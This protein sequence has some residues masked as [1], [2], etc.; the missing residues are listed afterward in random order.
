MKK[1]LNILLFLA[2][3]IPCNET[4]AQITFEKTFGS[5][6]FDQANSVRQTPDGGY[7]IGG[8][9]LLKIDEW[10]ALEWTKPYPSQFAN[11]TFDGGYILITSSSPDI[12][13]TKVD[14]DGDTVWQTKN[15]DGIWANEGF[16]ITQT[17][18][19]GYIV[20]GRYQSVTGSGMLLMKL[21]KT[22]NKLWRTTFTEATSA[23]FNTGH[24]VQQTADNGYIIT[25]TSQINY[26]DSTRNKDVFIVK[27]DS[28]G[29]EK[30]RRFFGG[31]KDDAG[32]F[33]QQDLDKNYLISGRTDSYVSGFGTDMYLIKLDTN[34]DSLWTKT[35]G[36]NFM[37]TSSG[38]WTTTDGGYILTGSSNTFSNGDFD[39]YVV[40]TNNNGDTLWTKHYGGTGVDY[41]SSVQQTSDNGY[42]FAGLTSILGSG[43]NNM[44]ILKTDSLGEVL[45]P[46][47]VTKKSS[48]SLNI[49]VY[50]NPS[51]GIF[52]IKSPTDK[53]TV[54]IINLLGQTI[55]SESFNS[56]TIQI[57]LSQHPKGAYFYQVMNS[58]SGLMNTG[59]IVIQ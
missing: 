58:D 11:L 44:Y 5:T 31:S 47:G 42:I 18:D 36:G 26:Y 43:D 40:K 19:S 57:D 53:T 55:Y 28:L 22:G 17:N 13:F 25:G 10:G 4:L 30:W 1:D 32:Y 20:T 15:R 27:T 23:G 46:N 8:T 12:V 49:E 41:L 34:G 50:P 56:G 39:G 7:I 2:L 54:T 21:N 33:V 9:N 45:G 14:I 59:K 37:E 52:N 16:F 38:L 3:L 51:S 35:Y 48:S 6:S 29:N 24:S